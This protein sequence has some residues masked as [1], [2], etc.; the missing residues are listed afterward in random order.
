[1]NSSSFSCRASLDRKSTRLNSSHHFI[2]Y[3][4]FCLKKYQP[5]SSS[6]HPVGVHAVCGSNQIQHIGAQQL[7]AAGARESASHVRIQVRRTYFFFLNVRR[8]RDFSP[9]P[10]PAPLRS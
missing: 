8:A 5:T 9:L 7:V 3:A 6:E 2:S 4:V 10:L 1:M